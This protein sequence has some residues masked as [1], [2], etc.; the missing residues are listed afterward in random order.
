V[1]AGAAIADNEVRFHEEVIRRSTE[2]AAKADPKTATIVDR[3]V[4]DCAAYSIHYG[5][6]VPAEA[7]IRTVARRLQTAFLLEELEWI[8]DRVRYE[9]PGFTQAITR[10]LRQVYRE[11]RVEIRDVPRAPLDERVEIILG[12]I[13]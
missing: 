1:S 13:D 8:N 12:L 9:A 4:I 10:R 2:L 5:W 3:T 11:A 7:A 6:T